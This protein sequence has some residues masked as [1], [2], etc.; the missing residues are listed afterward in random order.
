MSR[1]PSFLIYSCSF[2][3]PKAPEPGS[4]WTLREIHFWLGEPRPD[5]GPR[6]GSVE[7]VEWSAGNTQKKRR[8]GKPKKPAESYGIIW[9]F[10]KG[11]WNLWEF[12]VI[13]RYPSIELNRIHKIRFVGTPKTVPWSASKLVDSGDK[14]KTYMKAGSFFWKDPRRSFGRIPEKGTVPVVCCNGLGTSWSCGVVKFQ[15]EK[16]T[17]QLLSFQWTLGVGRLWVQ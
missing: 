13:Q 15:L 10:Q 9:N 2:C 1:F 11:I 5:R 12:L 3:F 17:F 16:N 6:V 4:Q 8:C 14:T 7:S